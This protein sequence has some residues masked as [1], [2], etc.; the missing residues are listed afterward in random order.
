MHC[1]CQRDLTRYL[2]ISLL[3]GYLYARMAS[4]INT[5]RRSIHIETSVTARFCS[6]VVGGVPALSSYRE[7]QAHQKRVPVVQ[8]GRVVHRHAGLRTE[9]LRGYHPFNGYSGTQRACFLQS[10]RRMRSSYE[11]SERVYKRGDVKGLTTFGDKRRPPKLLK[12][13]SKTAGRILRKLPSR[14]RLAGSNAS[15][16]CL[17]AWFALQ[18]GCIYS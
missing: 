11:K 18:S 1:A 12:I 15:V 16:E 13:C 9:H 7:S 5:C 10:S 8:T 14:K 3:M 4:A 6:V 2:S 17:K